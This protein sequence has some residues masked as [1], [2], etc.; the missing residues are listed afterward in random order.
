MIPADAIH[1][2]TGQIQVSVRVIDA[3]QLEPAPSIAITNSESAV[4]PAALDLSGSQVLLAALTG[5][6]A[7]GLL[8][9]AF[10]KLWVYE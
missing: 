1:E 4:K 7:V 3:S 10:L 5:L 6:C 8:L 9:W 2:N